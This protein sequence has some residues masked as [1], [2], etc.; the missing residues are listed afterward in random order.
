M[1]PYTMENPDPAWLAE[2]QAADLEAEQLYWQWYAAMEDRALEEQA[3]QQ[4]QDL[5]A[6]GLEAVQTDLF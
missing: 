1:E 5:E 4:A 3:L 6:E 2:A